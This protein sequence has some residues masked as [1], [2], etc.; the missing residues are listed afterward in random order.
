MSLRAFA[1]NYDDVSVVPDL[2]FVKPEGFSYQPGK[3]VPNHGIPDL[4]TADDTQSAC[5]GGFI[6]HQVPVSLG[7]MD[8]VDLPE[9]LISFD[10][11]NVSHAL[12]PD[13]KE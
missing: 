13:Q 2:V 7:V 6:D 5:S 1:R 9:I 10:R 12:R 4:L 3:P 8:P 11:L